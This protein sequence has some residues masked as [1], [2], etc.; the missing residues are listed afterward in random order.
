MAIVQETLNGGL[1]TAR[2]GTLLRAGEL[3]QA[4]NCIYLPYDPSLQ[5]APGRSAFGTVLAANRVK[6]VAHLAF[7]NATDLLLAYVGPTFYTAPW[8]ASTGTFTPLS[9]LSALPDN[10]GSPETL[11]VVQYFGAYY[12]L[13]SAGRPQR[14]AYVS[15][16]QEDVALCTYVGAVVTTT[17][18][19]GF[20]NCVLGQGV[21]ISAGTPALVAGTTIIAKNANNLSI[22]LSNTPTG[23]GTFTL[24][25]GAVPFLTARQ[26]GLDPVDGV[27]FLATQVVVGSGSWNATLGNGYY[28]FLYTE[29]IVPGKID[30]PS[31]GFVE[32]GF[33]GDMQVASITT[34]ASQK[35]TITRGTNPVN[36]TA[37]HW[38][39][40]MSDRLTTAS[41]KPSLATFKRVGGI[42]PISQTFIDLTETSQV[43]IGPKIATVVT[44]VGGHSAFSNSS[45]ALT[46]HDG[47]N[48]ASNAQDA[49]LSLRT[50][51]LNPGSGSVRGITARVYASTNPALDFANAKAACYIRIRRQDG[52]KTST[53]DKYIEVTATPQPYVVG[54]ESDTW[55][56]TWALA[57]FADANFELW[58]LKAGSAGV[59]SLWIDGVELTL[60]MTGT[61]INRDG[62][63][64]RTVT[65]TSQVGTTVSDTACLPPPN[66]STGEIYNGQFVTNDSSQLNA[67][68]YSIPDQPEYFPKPY[69]TVF[70]TRRGDRVTC[71]RKVGQSLIVGMLSQ[72]K[73]VNYLSTEADSDQ[74]RG[75]SY[76]DLSTD[77]GITGPMAACVFDM[78]RGGPTLAYCSYK[79]P[80]IT[81]AVTV[82]DLNTDLNWTNAVDTANLD[83]AIFRNYP[84]YYMLA[85]Y[86]APRG[87]NG[88]NT[89][90]LYFSYSPDKIKSD[91]TL[92]CLGPIDVSARSACEAN[93]SGVPKLLTGHNT[94]GKVYLEDSGTVDASG[95][96]NVPVWRSRIFQTAGI[97]SETRQQ[98]MYVRA[99]GVTSDN[100]CNLTPAITTIAGS[101]TATLVSGGAGL[102]RGWYIYDTSTTDPILQPGTV[103]TLI[104]GATLTLSQPAL[105]T[106][107]GRTVKATSGALTLTVRGASIHETVSDL[108]TTIVPLDATATITMSADN[109]RHALEVKGS[110][111]ML[112]DGTLI[113]TNSTMRIHHVSYDEYSGGPEA[114]RNAA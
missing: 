1:V 66:S 91:G 13:T 79:G 80:R 59:Q 81:N 82:D 39:V 111:S 42:I 61:N 18:V 112:P 19:K 28:Y 90:A 29:M 5:R 103:L 70:R 63:S 92:P 108:S 53:V 74:Q 20:A 2:D 57:D 100:T 83:K 88:T 99:D 17:T 6:G 3:Q 104:S 10:S 16:Q 102:A 30:D 46:P 40:Y 113:D 9:W 93:L 38:Q 114:S 105:V 44:T 85:L 31:T 51:G 86:Y 33:T 106:A 47:Q 7:D 21:T 97:D 22:T 78:P 73:R 35:V 50:F 49:A 60:N 110:F 95:G 87:G 94:D 75:R 25:M 77:S 65:Y 34:Y 11:D 71:V 54:G 43:T 55:G 107:T 14:I 27:S 4:D 45:G 36:T 56:E 32:S 96:V 98:T 26:A 84:K 67:I 72:L 12:A 58:I 76:D 64:F 62:V 101:L 48:A 24:R 8:T 109:T 68:A 69:R 23:A 15:P 89:K 52:V 41:P 37:T